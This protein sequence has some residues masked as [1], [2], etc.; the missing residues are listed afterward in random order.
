MVQLAHVVCNL[1][2]SAR[3][4]GRVRMHVRTPTYDNST[5]QGDNPL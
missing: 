3:R 2:L 1:E 4:I 5:A